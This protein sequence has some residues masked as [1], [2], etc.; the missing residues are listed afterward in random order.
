MA[1][2]HSEVSSQAT[3]RDALLFRKPKRITVTVPDQIY[4]TL[5]ERSTR[6]APSPIWLPIFWNGL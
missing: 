5:L 3:N 6:E 2:S 4:R 1:E